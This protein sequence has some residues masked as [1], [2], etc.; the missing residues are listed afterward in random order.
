MEAA[1]NYPKFDYPALGGPRHIRLIKIEPSDRSENQIRISFLS[2][3]LDQPC[4]FQT[5]SYAWG[6]TFPDG[7]HLTEVIFCE[8]QPIRV[9]SNLRSFLQRFRSR[10]ADRLRSGIGL[11]LW[12]DA[13]SIDQS[14]P[15]E[16]SEQ[17][18]MM[19]E[20]YKRCIQFN[21]WLGEVHVSQ[22]D[23]Y[24]FKNKRAD[25]EAD[26]SQYDQIFQLPWFQRR[27]VVQEV[28]SAP[29]DRRYI[30]IGSHVVNWLDFVQHAQ[31]VCKSSSLPE[32]FGT[33]PVRQLKNSLLKNLWRWAHTECGDPRDRIYA[34]LSLSKDSHEFTVDYH[35]K[36]S[37]VY[38]QVAERIVQYGSSRC[39]R[40]LLI[41]A[42]T[43]SRNIA[44]PTRPFWVP[45]WTT[46]PGWT[47]PQER[48]L[49]RRWYS[50]D[51]DLIEQNYQCQPKGMYKTEI[52]IHHRYLRLRVWLCSPSRT[53]E[54]L[55]H[56]C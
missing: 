50:N 30:W 26:S 39:L 31:F 12:I 13:L 52:V 47:T 7:S 41:T 56:S 24:P 25:R 15:A 6:E 36:T 11:L 9:T 28:A 32:H 22:G 49:L 48:R 23:R 17:V 40:A 3:D 42:I 34:L 14:N 8:G 20:I 4:E 21:I 38:L 45:N 55:H 29:E 2:A 33:P 44:Q 35:S 37:F 10:S 19:S 54:I 27:W 5:L 46:T 43:R 18:A 1:Q 51:N 16:R 53:E